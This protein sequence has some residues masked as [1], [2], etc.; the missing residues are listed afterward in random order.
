MKENSEDPEP[1]GRGVCNTRALYPYPRG[2]VPEKRS[3][4]KNLGK[5]ATDDL[6][7]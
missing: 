7:G 2:E 3:K 1:F 4:Q 5:D 6:T